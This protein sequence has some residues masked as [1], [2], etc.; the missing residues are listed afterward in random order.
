MTDKAP[1]DL[2]VAFAALERSEWATWPPASEKLRIRVLADA[3]EVAT[4]RAGAA[5]P[6]SRIRVRSG[7]FGWL[8]MFDIWSGAAVA[9]VTLCLFV[10]VGVG[11]EA[12]SEV[13]AQVGLDNIEFASAGDDGGEF[14]PFED[15]L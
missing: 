9:T 1:F 15:V 4:G 5:E 11:Y 2:D 8:R 10:G 3:A 6:E 12:G 13:M 14:S 7:G